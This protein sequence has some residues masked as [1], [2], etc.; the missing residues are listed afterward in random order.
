VEFNLT[1]S[2]TEAEMKQKT[3]P[4][5]ITRTDAERIG[6]FLK[7]D[8]DKI[9]LDEFHKGIIVEFEHAD[10]I[11][12]NAIAAG[13]IALAHLKELPDYYTRLSRIERMTTSRD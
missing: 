11:D 3:S 4:P 6:N 1:V 7:V 10:I 2:L 12:S 8:W 5:S 13:K 9:S